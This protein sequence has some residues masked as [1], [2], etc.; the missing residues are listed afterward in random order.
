[1]SIG[2]SP[3]DTGNTSFDELEIVIPAYLE[4]VQCFL[5]I[6]LD[7][8]KRPV[9][10]VTGFLQVV[11]QLL[12]LVVKIGLRIGKV[13]GAAAFDFGFLF[14]IRQT[15]VFFLLGDSFS[16]KPCIFNPL[17][18]LFRVFRV[19]GLDL[20][21]VQFLQPLN[22]FCVAF[23]FVFRQSFLIFLIGLKLFVEFGDFSFN[24]FFGFAGLENL[25]N[26]SLMLLL[27]L[28]LALNGGQ[29]TVNFFLLGNRFGV[30]SFGLA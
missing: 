6:R 16:F 15:V 9:V 4:V 29:L 21:G 28:A 19:D 12:C 7:V 5:G 23:G 17:P 24:L 25:L 26:I 30:T 3:G 18:F 11:V 8:G 14:F 20:L 10:L 27:V 2:G 22:G 1:M 13:F